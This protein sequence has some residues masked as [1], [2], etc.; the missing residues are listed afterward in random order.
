MMNDFA[1]RHWDIQRAADN[2]PSLRRAL[3]RLRL[4]H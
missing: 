1:L 4:L 3:D 2:V